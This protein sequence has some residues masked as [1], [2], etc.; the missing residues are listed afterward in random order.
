MGKRTPE[1][2]PA[3]RRELARRVRDLKDRTRYI[4]AAPTF[5]GGAPGSTWTIYAPESDTYGMWSKRHPTW[6]VMAF[7]REAP[8]R[9]VLRWLQTERK[10]NEYLR[11]VP[12]KVNEKGEAIRRTVRFGKRTPL[13]RLRAKGGAE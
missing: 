1:F 12:C 11:V 9:A 13:R 7:K 2:S 5:L 8:A 6:G 10:H 3:F 4:I